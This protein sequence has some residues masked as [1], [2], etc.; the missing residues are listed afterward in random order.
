MSVKSDLPVGKTFKYK[1][2]TLKVEANDSCEGCYFTC[3]QCFQPKQDSLIPFCGPGP[4]KG[5]GNV[6]FR[7]MTPTPRKPAKRWRQVSL[8][9]EVL[10]RYECLQCG[11]SYRIDFERQNSA[12][13]PA[14][15]KGCDAVMRLAGA[16]VF[17]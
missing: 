4:C 5:G 14:C 7:D 3:D 11:A 13:T 17:L 2:R 9:D 15:P 1:R 16:E 10:F 8:V 6:I 12:G